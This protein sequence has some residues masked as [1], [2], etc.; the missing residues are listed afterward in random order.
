[1]LSRSCVS[2]CKCLH[3]S[4]KEELEDALVGNCPWTAKLICCLQS[5]KHIERVNELARDPPAVSPL[6]ES[7]QKF[8][9]LDL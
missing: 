4:R 2:K 3:E 9:L 1:M 7:K 6:W 8:K 5:V